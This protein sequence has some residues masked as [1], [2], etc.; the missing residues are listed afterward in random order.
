MRDW[1]DYQNDMARRRELGY[2]MGD[3]LEWVT[4]YFGYWTED[5]EDARE[6]LYRL[7]M[8]VERADMRNGR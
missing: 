7:G 5:G 8:L 3:A 1:Q 4:H 2:W 6:E